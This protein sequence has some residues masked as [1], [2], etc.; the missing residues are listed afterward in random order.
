MG[1]CKG[2]TKKNLRCKINVD[3][4]DFCHHHVGQALGPTLVPI[5]KKVSGYIYVYTLS[6]LLSNEALW[7]KARNLPGT[8]SK[9][10]DQWL[11]F[12][13]R[14]PFT[15]IKVGM[16]TTSVRRRLKQWEDQ[17]HHRLTS[18]VPGQRLPGRKILWR[19]VVEHF[20][21]LSL[22]QNAYSTFDTAERG[23]Y[24][25]QVAKTESLVHQQLRAIYGHGDVYCKTCKKQDSR[26]KDFERGSYNVHVEWFLIPK[27][28]L[29]RVFGIIDSTIRHKI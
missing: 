6:E 17:C 27:T 10:R 18:L 16:T 21:N 20:A 23:F 3:K 9:Y 13:K 22:T 2:V 15:L 7:L 4:G 14:S 8:P 19:R 28:D 5:A 1:Q 25:P 29:E 11:T 26:T 24:L 12:E